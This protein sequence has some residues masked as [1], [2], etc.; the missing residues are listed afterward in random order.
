VQAIV[1]G[2]YQA[3]GRARQALVISLLR[4]FVLIIPCVLILSHF[5][6]TTGVWVA[7]SVTDVLSALLVVPMLSAEIRR[8]RK[9]E[10]AE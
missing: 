5:F 1:G 10:I 6:G 3:I 4:G 2:L 8:I 7:F 9:L